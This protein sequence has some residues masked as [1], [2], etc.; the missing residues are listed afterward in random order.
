MPGAGGAGWRLDV[1]EYSL[2]RRIEVRSCLIRSSHYTSSWFLH[3][4][5]SKAIDPLV[6]ISGFHVFVE[7]VRR[8][9]RHM[10][11]ILQLAS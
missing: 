10:E 5:V 2:R 9:T 4:W 3:S 6:S 7:Y 1:D 8:S 11:S